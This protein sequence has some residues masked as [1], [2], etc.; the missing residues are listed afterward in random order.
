MAVADVM[1]VT[2]LGK[3]IPIRSESGQD[4]IKEVAEYVN[5]KMEEVLSA[6][7]TAASVNVAILAAMNIAD[8]YFKAVGKNKE[9]R[10]QLE[11]KV[12]EMIFFIDQKLE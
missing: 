11:K 8:D 12:D 5:D 9:T 3:K 10:S 7:R 2:I 4:Y 1:E 6:S